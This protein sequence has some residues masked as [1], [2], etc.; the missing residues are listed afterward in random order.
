MKRS[1]PYSDRFLAYLSSGPAPAAS[2]GGGLRE[3]LIAYRFRLPKRRPS[4]WT[5]FN[6]SSDA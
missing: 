6:S 4:V 2:Y 5:L 1:E 3:A